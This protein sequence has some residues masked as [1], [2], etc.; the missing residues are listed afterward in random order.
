MLKVE[1]RHIFTSLEQF[2]DLK[3]LL[4]KGVS[5]HHSGLIPIFKEI[6]EILFAQKLVK[7]LFATETFAVGVNMP[8]KTVLFTE[9]KKRDNKSFRLLK[10]NEFTQMSGRAGRRGIDTVGHV[11][12]LPNLFNDDD[13]P[14]LLEIRQMMQGKSQ[15]IISKFVLDYQFVLKNRAHAVR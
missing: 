1:N 2:L 6:V 5:V 8:T 14:S 13:V 15:P 11:V 12:L 3:R 7:V 4:L 10:T 9:L